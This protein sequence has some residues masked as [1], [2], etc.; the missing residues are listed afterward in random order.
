MASKPFE[1]GV[2]KIFA[3]RLAELG[4]ARH[5][6]RYFR[7]CP[8]W[9]VQGL[10]LQQ[11]KWNG[12]GFCRFSIIA[13]RSLMPGSDP[14]RL[15]ARAK[16][17]EHFFDTVPGL[18]RGGVWLGEVTEVR[19]DFQYNYPPDDAAGIEAALREALADIERYGLFWLR[20]GFRRRGV[21]HDTA[22]RDASEAQQQ[23]YFDEMRARYPEPSEPA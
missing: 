7:P 22:R 6:V 4:F 9:G 19:R 8:P 20:W 5:G 13:A 3:P 21:R 12:T 11:D 2:R 16:A 17:D 1:A 23:A 18:I 10:L 14:A 15:I